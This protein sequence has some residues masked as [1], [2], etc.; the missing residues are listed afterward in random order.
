MIRITSKLSKSQNQRL[1]RAGDKPSSKFT[2]CGTKLYLSCCDE[3]EHD[4]AR[5]MMVVAGTT[6][7]YEIV[8]AE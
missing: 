4:I 8:H 5:H 1:L 2:H 7:E 3:S 6:F